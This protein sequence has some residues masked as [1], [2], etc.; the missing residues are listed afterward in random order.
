MPVLIQK[1]RKKEANLPALVSGK[2]IQIAPV[3]AESSKP[4][5]HVYLLYNII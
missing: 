1:R 5:I 3:L 2:W 4:M